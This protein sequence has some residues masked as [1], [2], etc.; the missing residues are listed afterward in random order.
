MVTGEELFMTLVGVATRQLKFKLKGTLREIRAGTHSTSHVGEAKEIY[1]LWTR[2]LPMITQYLEVKKTLSRN[3][4]PEAFEIC[5][6]LKSCIKKV[7]EGL[8][9][10]LRG[11]AIG[12][13]GLIIRLEMI[14]QPWLGYI[15]LISVIERKEKKFDSYQETLREVDDILKLILKNYPT[16]RNVI[17]GAHTL[18]HHVKL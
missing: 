17:L 8:L 6:K 1:G 4:N 14:S 15:S 3:V 13:A 7:Q 12:R 5:R 10:D 11:A 2:L 18:G 16:T 9:T